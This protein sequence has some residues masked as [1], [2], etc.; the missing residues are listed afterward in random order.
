MPGED[1]EIADDG[2]VT[3]TN[4]DGVGSCRVVMVSL[5]DDSNV[6]LQ[7]SFSVQVF[8]VQSGVAVVTF[9]EPHS[10]IT[11]IDNDRKHVT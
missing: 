8:E 10:N 11:I 1:F 7:E 2:M 4:G 9:T 6:E 5:I 3:F